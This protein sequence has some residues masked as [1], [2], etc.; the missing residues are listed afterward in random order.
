MIRRRTELLKAPVQ[1]SW[2]SSADTSNFLSDTG[3]FTNGSGTITSANRLGTV[4]IF[5]SADSSGL[6]TAI[7]DGGSGNGSFTINGV[8]IN[9]DSSTNSIN[10]IMDSINSSAA[11]VTASYNAITHQFS[12]TNNT[13]GNLGITMADNTGNFLA[14]TGLSS[15]TTTLGNNLQYT[16][17]GSGIL[18]SN[19]NTINGSTLGIN[20][21]SITA[22]D[23]GTSTIAVSADTSTISTAITNF[24]NDYNTGTELHFVANFHDDY[25]NGYATIA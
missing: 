25:A 4:N 5:T 10:D 17:N 6:S 20:G 16:L 24:V 14:A 23:T 13:T 8:T 18:T 7:S 3:L 15:G 21:L 1:S 22:E 2:G 9:Y 19:S 11:G 12:L